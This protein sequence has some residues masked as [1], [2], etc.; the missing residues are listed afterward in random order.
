M[1]G[2]P[3]G[4]APLMRIGGEAAMGSK[5]VTVLVDPTAQASPGQQ[6]CLMSDFDRGLSGR[7]I[8]IERQQAM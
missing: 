3:A 7:R 4:C 1:T 8:A 2:V 5:V 6:Q